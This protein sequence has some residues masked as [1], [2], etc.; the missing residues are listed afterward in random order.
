LRSREVGE[1][2]FGVVVGVVGDV[3]SDSLPADALEFLL[4]HAV[5]EGFHASVVGRVRFDEVDEVEGVLSEPARVV[6]LEEVP[7]REVVGV[8]VGLHDQVVLLAL[9]LRGPP[10]VSRLE[11]ALELQSVVRLVVHGVEGRQAV[12]VTVGHGLALL[13]LGQQRLLLHRQ[14]FVLFVVRRLLFETVVHHSLLILSKIIMIALLLLFFLFII[15]NETFIHTQRIKNRFKFFMLSGK[16]VWVFEKNLF[17][18][19]SRERQMYL[20]RLIVLLI[21]YLMC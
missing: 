8:V 16:L 11:T 3:F 1:L 14:V 21:E 13:G 4:L 9:H 18:P 12:E 6:D 19:C 10:E 17:N 7:L 20:L 15:I 2:G 5:E